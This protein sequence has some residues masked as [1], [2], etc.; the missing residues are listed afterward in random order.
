M[1]AVFNCSYYIT[2]S[3][4]ALTLATKGSPCWS[5]T[6][7]QSWIAD[8]GKEEIH[9]PQDPDVVTF[10]DNN[11]VLEKKWKVEVNYKSRASVI[12][13]LIHII[14]NTMDPHRLQK[15]PELSPK[16]WLDFS[17]TGKTNA[18]QKLLEDDRVYAEEFRNFRN[19]YIDHRLRKLVNQFDSEGH[20]IVENNRFCTSHA[21]ASESTVCMYPFFL[22]LFFLSCRYSF[23][24]SNHTPTASVMMGEPCFENP[25]S[26]EAV[27]KVRNNV[28]AALCMCEI[29][30]DY[31]FM[32]NIDYE[33][34][35]F[36]QHIRNTGYLTD[37]HSAKD[38]TTLSG[39]RLDFCVI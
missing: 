26:Y 33:V 27:E 1:Q 19:Q 6:T 30:A 29:D 35:A 32:Y 38:H 11:Q 7:I 12:I 13:T 22:Y 28:C 20:D 39:K 3:K 34:F 17:E 18:V 4:S 10:F 24:K 8:Q 9:C 37:P 2:G 16:M 5:Y 31:A 15:I 23:I 36:R 21:T 25:C 14:P